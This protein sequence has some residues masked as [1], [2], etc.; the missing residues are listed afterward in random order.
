MLKKLIGLNL[1]HN[2]LIGT[3]PAEIGEIES[4]E[5]LDLSFNQPSG[6]IPRSISRLSSLGTLKLSHNNLSKEIPREGHLSTFNDASSFDENPYLCGNPLPKK[7]TSENSFQPPF[8]NIENQD[9][10]EDKWEKWLLYIMIILGY[11][12]GFWG[13]VGVLI[14]KRSWRY[15]Y[16]NFVDETKD[17]IHARVHRSIETLKGMCIHK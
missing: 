10:E 14:L 9:E 2:N 1:S 17:K 8:R 5:S 15:A 13:V 12:V 3:I 6:P 7:C 4:L 11:V 16:F